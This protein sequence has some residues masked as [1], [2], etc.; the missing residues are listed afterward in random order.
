M[1]R[2]SPTLTVALSTLTVTLV[3]ASI[4]AI[5]A[6]VSISE[7][8][9]RED[10]EL[11]YG[12]TSTFAVNAALGRHLDPA[13]PLLAEARQRAER[14]PLAADDPPSLSDYLVDKV[15]HHPDVAFFYPLVS[16]GRRT[17]RP[18]LD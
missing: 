6:V 15:R 5:V 4:G 9:G 7:R 12:R 18:G 16:P 17:A 13:A 10:I 8:Q 11:R 1:R 3:L 14:G 2:R